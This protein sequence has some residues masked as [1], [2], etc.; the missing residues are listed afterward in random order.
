MTNVKK[1][2]ANLAKPKENK[3]EK[4][5]VALAKSRKGACIKFTSSGQNGMPDRICLF[6]GGEVWFVELKRQGKK[7]DPLQLIMHEALRRLGFKVNVISNEQELKQFE[8]EISAL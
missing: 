4:K 5:L 2:L 8:N 3:I 7:P 1:Q 6:P